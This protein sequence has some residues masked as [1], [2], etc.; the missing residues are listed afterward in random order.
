M[1]NPYLVLA[2]VITF[3]LNGFYWN[4][5]GH[6][7]ENVAW[8]AKT[9][10][11]LADASE[12]ARKQQSMWQGVVDG[13]VKNYEAKVAGIRSTLDTALNS[14]RD[15]PERAAGVSE[16][17]RIDC[18]GGTGAELSRPDGEFLEREAARANTIRAGLVACYE[19]IDGTK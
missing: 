11:E 19:V 1:P 12:A 8:K 3:V 16:A 15:R 4:A 9:Y 6:N 14:L 10:Q 13:T 18:A 2:V 7:A 17:P 5:H